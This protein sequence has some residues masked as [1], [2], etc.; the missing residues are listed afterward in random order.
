M[1]GSSNNMCE[2]SEKEM[3]TKLNALNPLIVPFLRWLSC[4]ASYSDT[5]PAL[6][7]MLHVRFELDFH[8]CNAMIDYIL[9]R[10]CFSIEH[11]IFE[12]ILCLYQ[13]YV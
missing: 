5:P 7:A 4:A 13:A 2:C 10:A 8:D 6:L 3:R 9:T 12:Q 1:Q 11:I